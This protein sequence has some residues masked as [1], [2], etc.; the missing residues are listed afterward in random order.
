LGPGFF[1]IECAVDII[2]ERPIGAKTEN[3]EVIDV[4]LEFVAPL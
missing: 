1:G 2:S 3:S 4:Q